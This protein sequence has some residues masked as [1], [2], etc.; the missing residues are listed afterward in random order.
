MLLINNPEEGC[1]SDGFWS[2]KLYDIWGEWYSAIWPMCSKMRGWRFRGNFQPMGKEKSRKAELALQAIETRRKR[3][4]S[5]IVSARLMDAAGSDYVMWRRSSVGYVGSRCGTKLGGSQSKTVVRSGE[6]L[7]AGMTFAFAV[8]SWNTCGNTKT[9]SVE[10]DGSGELLWCSYFDRPSGR[11]YLSLGEKKNLLCSYPNDT[12]HLIFFALNL[13]EG[14]QGEKGRQARRPPGEAG[15]DRCTVMLR[16]HLCLS[17]FFALYCACGIII[18]TI[19][20]KIQPVWIFIIEWRNG[21]S[22]WRIGW[23]L[24]TN[25]GGNHVSFSPVFSFYLCEM[26]SVICHDI[27]RLF[28]I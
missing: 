6:L 2:W 22:F 11:I 28:F 24:R 26:L 3:R 27:V 25:K 23:K 15:G 19:L 14:R 21:V 9:I 13:G 17:R 5:W 7:Q 10:E 8:H 20:R 12:S 16:V 18:K 1:D 4:R